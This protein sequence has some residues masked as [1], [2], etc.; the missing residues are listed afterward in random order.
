MLEYIYSVISQSVLCCKEGHKYLFSDV[1]T[2]WDEALVEC[3]LYGGWLVN[4]GGVREHNC[5]LEFG[6][7]KAELVDKWYWTGGKYGWKSLEALRGQLIKTLLMFRSRQ[8]DPRGVDPR[9]PLRQHGDHLVP[10]EDELRLH[11]LPLLPRR[12]RLAPQHLR[13]SPGV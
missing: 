8:R 7:S 13:T 11:G 5:L 6:H 3:E 1:A 4:I 10:P 9:P 2:S 12:G